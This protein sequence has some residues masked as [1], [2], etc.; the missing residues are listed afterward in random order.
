VATGAEHQLVIEQNPGLLS[1]QEIERRLRELAEIKIHPRELQANIALLA[2][3]A[4]V[5]EE[6]TA[7]ARHEIGV[8]LLEFRAALE[9]QL[10]Q[11]IEAA[12]EYLGALLDQLEG[13]SSPLLS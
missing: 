8:R 2:R 1:P 13:D 7:A 11:R 12:R 5:Y 3:A 6:H 4:R 9:T 10:P